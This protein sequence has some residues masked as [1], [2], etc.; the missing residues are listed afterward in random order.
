MDGSFVNREVGM[1][2][3]TRSRN[4]CKKCKI[5][6]IKCDER[7][8][9]CQNCIRRNV[10]VCDY[11]K[12][13]RWGGRPYR[14]NNW[15]HRHGIIGK[16]T[17]KPLSSSVFLS[18][19][20]VQDL[21]VQNDQG[22]HSE[23][24]NKENS[25]NGNID[26]EI[27]QSSLILADGSPLHPPKPPQFI[28]RDFDHIPLSAFQLPSP[29]PDILLNTP[30][31]LE[32]FEFYMKKT[33][34]LLVP[35]PRELFS[36]NPFCWRFGQMALVCPSLL[37]LLLA[38]SS[39]H[40]TMIAAQK[41]QSEPPPLE[42]PWSL[43]FSAESS[44]V[45]FGD[46]GAG[47]ILTNKLLM[48]TFSKL[49]EDITDERR[50]KSDS[51]L[52]TIMMLAAF[53]IFFSDKRRKWRAHVNGAGNLIMERLYSSNC[54]MLT[55][56]DT[57]EQND[58]FFLTRWFSYVDIIGSLSSTS[59]VITTEKLQAIK[60]KSKFTDPSVLYSRRISLS[61]LEPGTGLEHTVLAYLADVSSLIKDKE[62]KQD[63]SGIESISQEMLSRVLE[64]DYEI[65][66]Y[67]ENSELERNQIYKKYYSQK[68]WEEY[69]KYHI[70]RI[71]NLIFGLTG[72]YQ[73]K[74]RVL[75][76]PLESKIVRDLLIRITE[77]VDKYVPLAAS[78][79][80][81]L[82]FCLFSCGSDLLHNSMAKYRPIYLRRIEALNNEGVNCAA[83]AKNIMNKCWK[84]KK[85]WWDLLRE[86]NLDITFAI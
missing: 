78:S 75:N 36:N 81:C 76:L 58:L 73:L 10:E 85:N 68:P 38:F 27:S 32:L 79:T 48:K 5:L 63:E 31:Y 64:L 35:L 83:M 52:A 86:E 41:I 60:Y 6:K 14:K 61:D 24:L 69:K 26:G 57:I 72:S 65:T 34:Y 1:A 51:T 3:F 49:L 56:Q 8:P 18:S 30:H 62:G 47:N 50:R 59:R 54:N 12:V 84:F 53:D 39:N 21:S 13:L 77:L 17:P 55:L 66:I 2:K 42:E 11:S 37:H 82:S 70:L 46:V 19:I 25:N 20:P 40:R 16:I 44:L 9:R 7:K 80:S 15:N 45:S 22:L 67:L 28:S 33:A 23:Y 4:G 43:G 71:T 74:R 29:L